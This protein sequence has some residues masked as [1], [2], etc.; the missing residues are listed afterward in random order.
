MNVLLSIPTMGPAGIDNECM[1]LDNSLRKSDANDYA[2]VQVFL[3]CILLQQTSDS[4]ST[5]VNPPLAKRMAVIAAFSHN[6]TIGCLFGS[7]GILMTS[8]EQRLGVSR[9][10]SSMGVSLVTVCNAL[11]SP[12]VGMLAARYSLRLL[13]ST[14]AVLS[15]LGYALLALTHSFS[16]YVVAYALL[17]GPGLALSGVV[18]PSTL[19]TRWFDKGR[20]RILGLVHMPIVVAIIPV[21]SSILLARYGAPITYAVFGALI[22]M[23]LVPMS[24]MIVD[25]PTGSVPQT[26]DTSSLTQVS[27]EAATASQILRSP[28]FWAFAASAAII[29]TGAIVLNTHMIPMVAVWGIS[30][31][32]AATLMSVCALAGIP[33]SIMWGWIADKIGGGPALAA[34][35]VGCAVLW[36]AL[37][38]NPS[39]PLALLLIGLLGVHGVASIPLMGMALS[40]AFGPAS[41]SR[42]YGLSTMMTLPFTVIGIQAASAMFVKTGSYVSIV[43]VLIAAFLLLAPLPY[44]ARRRRESFSLA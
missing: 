27:P 19:V 25:Y 29:I 23:I 9:E 13:F 21:L 10:L 37:L 26:A 36:A 3:G 18:L 12:V 38:T 8:V 16:L 22:A 35:A 31:T 6:I 15:V 33:G 28:R 30:A 34:C 7:F 41:F 20:G 24:L 1:S 32:A 42:A 40:E 14:G 43:I 2:S 5:G 11:L 17:L 4:A 44:L 39:Y